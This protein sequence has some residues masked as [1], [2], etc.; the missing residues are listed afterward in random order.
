MRGDKGRM[1]RAAGGVLWRCAGSGTVEVALVHR[2]AYDDWSLPKGKLRRG[3]HP[4]VTARRE[5]AEETGVR[6]VAGKRLDIQHYNTALGPKAVE[7]WAM[8]GPDAPFTPT[9]EV[10]QLAWLP[11]PDA[12]K[13]LDYQGDAYAVDALRAMADSA[14]TSSAVLLVRNAR[15]VPTRRWKGAEGDRSL[16]I[17]GQEQAEALRRALPAFGPSEL[18]SACGARFTGTMRPLG[19]ELGLTVETESAFGE[20]GYATHPRRGLTLILGLAG[21]DG[22]AA[23][24][25]PGAV[26]RHLLAALAEDSRLGSGR[27]PGKK[28]KRLGVVLLRGPPRHGGLLSLTRQPATLMKAVSVDKAS[29][30]LT[31]CDMRGYGDGRRSGPEAG[32]VAA[33]QVSLARCAR[34]RKAAGPPRPA[35]CAR[36]RALAPQRRTG[37]RP[38]PVLHRSPGPRDMAARAGRARGHSGGQL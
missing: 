2:P 28:G 10:D 15:A 23:V 29:R 14:V 26:I 20:D 33:R 13:R 30:F 9:A 12:L 18:L 11:L 5:V 17:R 32:A 27:I 16:D 4:L 38:G 24:C 21:A 25:A 6:G 36:Y 34:L 31:S 37:A 3:E 8:Q 1:I 35:G 7:Y 19:A 22:T